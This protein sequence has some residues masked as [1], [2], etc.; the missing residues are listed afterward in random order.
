MKLAVAALMILLS[1]P[2]LAQQHQHHGQ[3]PYVGMEARAIKA[4]SEQ[5]LSDLRAG[6]GMGMALAAE[7][8]GY[9]GPLHV[10]ELAERIGLSDEQKIRVRE[11]FEA[12]KVEAI[13]GGDK[14]IEHEAA[15]DRAFANRKMTAEELSALTREIGIAQGEL[16][17]VHLK[18]HLLVAEMLSAEQR[19]KYAELRGY[20]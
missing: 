13:A 12:M 5:Q 7:L 1:S 2:A 10:L 9:P 14:L 6:R 19:Q 16:R 18:Y 4:I 8:N 3:S 20:R 15:L 17:G 11:L